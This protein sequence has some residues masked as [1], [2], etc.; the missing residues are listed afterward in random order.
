MRA[1][2]RRQAILEAICERRVEKVDNL[3]F[4]FGV[5][6][7]TILNDILELSLSYPVYTQL[8]KNGGVYVAEGFYLGT[9]YLNSE[10]KMLLERLRETVE[11]KDKEI[12]ESILIGFTRPMKK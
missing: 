1:L 7:N 11:G 4:E 9:I 8:G 5:H 12:L 6:R 2:E 3:A 10:Q